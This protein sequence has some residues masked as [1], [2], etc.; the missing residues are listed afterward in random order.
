MVNTYSTSVE[1]VTFNIPIEL[2]EQVV[3]LKEEL[4]V[5]LSAI[6]NEAIANYIK[7]KE[8]EKWQRGVD[9]ALGDEDYMALTK[10][11][12]SDTGDIYEY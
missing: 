9:M 1:K 10:E 2:K 7:Q 11:L 3:A 6:Y 12:G 4:K 5:S 8:L